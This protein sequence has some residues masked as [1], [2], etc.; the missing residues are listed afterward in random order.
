MI[1]DESYSLLDSLK[2]RQEDSSEL[3]IL[4]G[5]HLTPASSGISNK[6]LG[7]IIETKNKDDDLNLL[8]ETVYHWMS[9]ILFS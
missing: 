4:N 7:S 3:K 2:G 5:N 9:K 6:I 1:F 8:I